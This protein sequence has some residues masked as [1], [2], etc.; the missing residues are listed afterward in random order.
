AKLFKITFIKCFTF[1]THLQEFMEYRL[2]GVGP[3]V[4]ILV[5]LWSCTLLLSVSLGKTHGIRV[6]VGVNI[7]SSLISLLLIYWPVAHIDVVNG[8][9]AEITQYDH[10][11]IPRLLLVIFLFLIVAIIITQYLTRT[12]LTTTSSK[13]VKNRHSQRTFDEQYRIQ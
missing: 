3:G 13:P 8:T 11:F 2:F 7:L 10:V 12:V 4:I 6:V 1:E 9:I 5:L